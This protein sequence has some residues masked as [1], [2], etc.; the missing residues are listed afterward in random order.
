M[1]VAAALICVLVPFGCAS[2]KGGDDSG[3]ATLVLSPSTSTLV[4]DD[5]AP[6]S[7]PFTATLMTPDGSAVDVTTQT[8]FGV[9][10]ELGSFVGATL[11]MSS[12]GPGTV[13]GLYMDEDSN[14]LIGS[15]SVIAQLTGVRIDPSLGSGAPDLFSGATEDPT[16]AP[17]VVYPPVGVVVPRNLGDFE[18]HWTDASSNNVWEVS[19]QDTY[20]DL[21]VYVPGGN[22]TGAG[23]D[24]SWTSFLPTEWLAAVGNSE[25]ITYQVRGADSTMPG[26][27]GSAPPESVDLSNMTMN[28][29]IYYWSTGG[30][31]SDGEG[32]WRHDMS[33]PQT[34]ATAFYTGA[35]LANPTQDA[36]IA[37]HVLSADGTKM[38]VTFQ[39]GNGSADEVDVASQTFQNGTNYWNFATYTPD[40]TQLLAV[41]A[42]NLVVRDQATQTVIGSMTSAGWVTHPS[43]SADGTMLVYTRPTVISCDWAFGGGEIITRTYDQS[44]ASFGA[45]TVLLQNSMNNYYPSFSPD[46]QWIVFNQSSDNTTAG[47]YNNPSATVWVIKA[48]GSQPPVELAAMNTSTANLTNSWPRWAPFAQSVG[49]NMTPI[50]WITMSSKRDFGVRLVGKAQPQLW[51]SPFFPGQAAMGMDPSAPAFWLP[52]QNI[53]SSNHIAQWTQQVIGLQ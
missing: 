49:A 34:P 33:K 5:G 42:G 23:P 52:F 17:T 20:V 21:K 51:M 38:A 44:S 30:T 39:G 46:G 32:I 24:P 19:L 13:T 10:E 8:L 27:V 12:S 35:Q 2:H 3:S 41:E 47:A 1:R 6:A 9:D 28:G 45:E 14:N 37:C 4:L 31:G 16:R 43:I 36:C 25:T 11:T 15:A 7:E 29:G 22:G 26:T 50:Y 18:V 53:D 48:D 40:G